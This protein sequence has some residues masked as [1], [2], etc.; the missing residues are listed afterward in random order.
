MIWTNY[1]YKTLDFSPANIPNTGIFITNVN[2]WTVQ[3]DEVVDNANDHW[4]VASTTLESWRLFTFEW[5]C[6][7][8]D[9]DARWTSWELLNS[10]INVEPFVDSNPYYT[11]TFNTDKWDA[12]YTLAKVR[13][14]PEAENWMCD[15]RIK[16]T[17][18]LYAQTNAIFAPVEQT[19]AWLTTF[20]WGTN[21]ANNF[22]DWRGNYTWWVLCLN[23]WNYKAW[24]ELTII[25][26]LLNPT[27][28]NLTNW[29]EYKISWTTSQLVV[30]SRNWLRTVNDLWADIK[31]KRNYWKPILL[32]PWSN[33]IIVTSDEWTWTVSAKWNSAWNT[34]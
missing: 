22:P 21:F 8:M 6:F 28:K 12:R 13:K 32:S 27:I 3:R 5:Y 9:K 33:I 19:A 7:G 29:L 14:K 11:L 18:E 25:W 26:N 24:I 17:F 31:Y 10:V 20:F 2:N 23:N 15:P 1:V 16:F 34:L 4:S 30:N